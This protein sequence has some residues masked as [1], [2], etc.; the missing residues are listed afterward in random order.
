MTQPGLFGETPAPVSRK[1][2]R[3]AERRRKE[4]LA[5][6]ATAD[7]WKRDVYQVFTERFLPDHSDFIFEDFT[8]F[9]EPY[10]K[11]HGLAMTV[12]PKAFA[13]LATRLRK[14]GLIEAVRDLYRNRTQGSPSQVYRRV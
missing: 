5:Y 6:D 9:Y 8:R 13:G 4:K 2:S 7:K 10:A 1:E 12:N 14:E 3:E 11:Q